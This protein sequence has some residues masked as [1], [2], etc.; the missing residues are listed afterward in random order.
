MSYWIVLFLEPVIIIS[1][2][3]WIQVLLPKEKRTSR[4]EKMESMEESPF[5]MD[6][7]TEKMT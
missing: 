1:N 2:W 7:K 3:Y 5:A 6:L 4:V